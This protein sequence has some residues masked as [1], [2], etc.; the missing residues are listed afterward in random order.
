MLAVFS[1][2][3]QQQ[4]KAAETRERRQTHILIELGL[5]VEACTDISMNMRASGTRYVWYISLR[6][7]ARRRATTPLKD[8]RKTETRISLPAVR[9]VL[10]HQYLAGVVI[11]WRGAFM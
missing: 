4:A 7:G 10:V 8:K 2:S 5:D 1:S 3:R 9:G 11:S 6:I